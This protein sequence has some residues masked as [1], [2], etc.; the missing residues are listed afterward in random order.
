[1]VCFGSGVCLNFK[2]KY[3]TRTSTFFT[4]LHTLACKL[5]SETGSCSRRP[6][7]FFVHFA[8]RVYHIL[9]TNTVRQALLALLV[10]QFI[11]GGRAIF[12]G[13]CALTTMDH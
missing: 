10:L 11:S 13:V 7:V 12:R 6:R 5:T 4:G 1:M 9:V 3:Y 8:S 2:A